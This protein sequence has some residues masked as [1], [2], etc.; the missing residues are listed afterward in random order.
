MTNQVTT[1]LNG[2]R[3]ANLKPKRIPKMLAILALEG[4]RRAGNTQ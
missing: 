2:G 4:Q 3:A 1:F